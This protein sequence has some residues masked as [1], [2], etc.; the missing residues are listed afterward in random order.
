METDTSADAKTAVHP[1]PRRLELDSLAKTLPLRGLDERSL[2]MVNLWG[3]RRSG[4]STL[5]SAL[6]ESEAMAQARVL[7]L[8]PTREG[9]VDTPQEFI[10]ACSK[11]VRYPAAPE[12]EEPIAE[13][14]E[15]SQRGKVN[16]MRSDD[17]I[18]ITRS[19]L[20]SKKKPYLNKAAA[21][22][23]GRTPNIR[24]DAEL[25]VGFEN[26]KA[27]NQ[28]E[29]FLDALPLQSLGTDLIIV[30]IERLSRLSDGLR[31]WIRD[32]VVPAATR[33]PYRRNLVF[34]VESTEPLAL[35]HESESFGSWDEQASDFRLQPLSEAES[36]ELALSLRLAPEAARLAAYSS[37]GFPEAILEAARAERSLAADAEADRQGY[38]FLES[39]EPQTLCKTAVCCLAETLRPEELD[40]A[41]GKGAGKPFFQWLQSSGAPLKPAASGWQLDRRFRRQAVGLAHALPEFREWRSSWAPHGR[42]LK[43][44][45]NRED[46]ARLP[47]FSGL[48]WIDEESVRSLFKDK[49]DPILEYLAK[50]KALFA[51]RAGR[52]RLSECLRADLAKIARRM[53][54]VGA[55]RLRRKAEALWAKRRE[56]FETEIADLER[57]IKIA[58]QE[59][60]QL[61]RQR[62]EAEAY[63]RVLKRR[64]ASEPEAGSPD[65]GRFRGPAI[66]ALSALAG[67]FFWTMTALEFPVSLF[68]LVGGIASLCTALGLVPG[69]RA[70]RTA[71]SDQDSLPASPEG[72]R[73]EAAKLL[74]AIQARESAI[75]ELE[76]QLARCRE[77]LRYPLVESN[78]ETAS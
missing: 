62:L 71:A 35:R 51:C 42:L 11:S 1:S 46:R 7:W 23:A 72:T 40:M 13:K 30:F 24:E 15:R 36:Y 69:W 78:G 43:Q 10:L 49:A 61:N 25:S 68:A 19:S 65:A 48:L 45:P 63:L 47:A 50:S 59:A 9:S 32:Y 20:A 22:A 52:Y 73:R 39:L 77:Q 76:A 5:V 55:A 64:G 8:Q 18:L 75:E 74:H 14:L 28:A 41:L 21:A 6:R 54:H 56:H 37:H 33:G 16:P 44:V 57:S 34:L 67:I 60:D 66:V 12:K 2:R 26:N 17:S 31:D 3:P 53:D 70:G 58:T 38:R 29:G 4:K 27:G